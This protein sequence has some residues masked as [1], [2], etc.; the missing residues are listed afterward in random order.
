MAF[1]EKFKFIFSK[2]TSKNSQMTKQAPVSTPTKYVLESVFPSR[3][4]QEQV[5]RELQNQK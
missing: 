3:D 5:L 4:V 2:H 1:L